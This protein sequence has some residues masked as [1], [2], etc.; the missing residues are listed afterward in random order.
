MAEEKQ[1]AAKLETEAPVAEPAPAEELAAKVEEHMIPKSRFDEINERMKAAEAGKKEW[2]E[3]YQKVLADDESRREKEQE[4]QDPMERMEKQVSSMSAEIKR[5]REEREVD[6]QLEDLDAR[7]SSLAKRY[8][9]ADREVLEAHAFRDPNW[10]N[11]EKYAKASQDKFQVRIEEGYKTYGKKKM[12][13]NA[14]KV[15]TGGMAVPG[16]D[17]RK[18]SLR[19]GSAKRAFAEDY[20]HATSSET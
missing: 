11:L 9:D 1:E 17:Q 20:G 7:L 12:D 15:E 2:E 4:P 13:T 3:W 18:L 6:A 14:T 16:P 19:D 8:P 10:D 5:L